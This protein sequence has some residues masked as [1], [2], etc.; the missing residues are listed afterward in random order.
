MVTMQGESHVLIETEDT[1][2]LLPVAMVALVG[3]VP[4]PENITD[5][6]SAVVSCS[7]RAVLSLSSGG[8]D[9]EQLARILGGERPVKN[10][11]TTTTTLHY[12]PQSG[13]PEFRMRVNLD[14]ADVYDGPYDCDEARWWLALP[15]MP[16]GK[17][18]TV[19]C[20]YHTV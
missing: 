1:R 7:G 12:R 2:A 5:K 9:A 4:P 14:G 15:P 18:M 17:K 11:D 6:G 20:Y 8:Y 13:S 19:D 10:G 3:P 16:S